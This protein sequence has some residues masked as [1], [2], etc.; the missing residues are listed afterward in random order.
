MAEEHK[1]GI[2]P[3]LVQQDSVLIEEKTQEKDGDVNMA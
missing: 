1:D 3:Q 2:D